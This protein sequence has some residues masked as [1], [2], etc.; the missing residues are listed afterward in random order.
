MLVTRPAGQADELLAAIEA[1]GG[2]AISFPSLEIAP[3]APGDVERVASGLRVADITVFVSPNAVR[4]GI[5]HAGSGAIAA[6]GPATARALA[7]GGRPVDVL[8]DAG[9]DS[10]HLLAEPRM[11][12]VRGKVVRI[13]RGTAGR[14][15]LAE[16][17]RERGAIVEYLPVYERRTPVVDEH[18]LGRLEQAWKAGEIDVVVVMSVESLHGLLSLLPRSCRSLLAASRLVT[19]AARVIKEA[20][21]LFPGIQVTL[22]DGPETENLLR[23]IAAPAPGQT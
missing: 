4:Y 7:D 14:E 18:R 10:E 22:A 15:L 19:P 5:D 20:L 1:A 16:T 11:R 3:L 17:L 2:K 13:V 12:D 8:A 21:S 23:A 6:V 9:F